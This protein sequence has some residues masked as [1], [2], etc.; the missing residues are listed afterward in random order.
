M[1]IQMIIVIAS[2]IGDRDFPN[3]VQCLVLVFLI[4]KER[5]KV[6]LINVRFANF[7]FTIIQILFKKLLE[8]RRLNLIMSPSRIIIKN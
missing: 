1:N 5:R 6:C 7:T 3:S 8:I 4:F 2:V